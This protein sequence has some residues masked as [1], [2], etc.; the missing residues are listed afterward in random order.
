MENKTRKIIKVFTDGGS[1]GNP[2]PSALGVFITDSEGEEIHGFG[3]TLGITTNNV[4][5]YTAVL[6]ALQWLIEHKTQCGENLFVQFS[7]DSRL[8]VMQLTG[9][10]RIKN[11][12]LSQLIKAIKSKEAELA[13]EITYTHIPRE[14]NKMADRYVNMALDGKI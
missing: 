13:C 14:L 7:M 9:K 4:A 8:A 2:G 5:E 12:N 3:R 1:R 11:E 10:F 6:D